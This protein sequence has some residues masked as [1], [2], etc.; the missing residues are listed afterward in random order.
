MKAQKI[1]FPLKELVS[2]NEIYTAA[3][4]HDWLWWDKTLANEDN[5]YEVVW[6]TDDEKNTIHYID[7]H[8]INLRYLVVQGEAVDEIAKQIHSSLATYTR[9][10]IRQTVEEATTRD[11][12]IHAIYQVGI[13]APQDYDPELFEWFKIGLSNPDAKVRKA[14]ILAIGYVGWLE[15]RAVL[16]EL[17]T[18]DPD[19][20]VRQRAS[21]LLEG[22]ETS[23]QTDSIDN[24]MNWVLSIQFELSF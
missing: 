24:Q 15:F 5:P 18:N 17:K 9:E 6:I 11:Q 8:L 1:R 14:T 12:Y 3:L 2:E 4:R 22:Y 7:D 16:Q 23:A 10:E 20:S 19:Q 13:A 21:I